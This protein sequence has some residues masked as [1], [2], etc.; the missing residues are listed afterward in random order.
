M[1][2]K[3]CIINEKQC[4]CK[5][6]EDTDCRKNKCGICFDNDEY[7]NECM[8]FRRKV[9]LNNTIDVLT[10]VR[11]FCQ[12]RYDLCKRILN[13]TLDKKDIE[14]VAP[15]A[16]ESAQSE[17]MRVIEMIN[18]LIEEVQNAEDKG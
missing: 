3:E 1:S 4:A 15:I 10:Y 9:E 14:R 12:K 13:R 16:V 5:D 17:Q 8:Y 7:L 11:E 2:D 18:K 6:C